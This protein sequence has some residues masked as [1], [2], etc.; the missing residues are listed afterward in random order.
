MLYLGRSSW[1]HDCVTFSTLSNIDIRPYL[2]NHGIINTVHD[3]QIIINEKN[4]IANRLQRENIV[5]DDNMSICPKHRSSFGIDWNSNDTT[6]HHPDHAH[7]TEQRISF[8]D[9][10]L[11]NLKTCTKIEGFPIGGR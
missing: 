9:F 8:K 2:K 3:D 10:R 6:C 5:V 11:A 4:L 7:D 1:P